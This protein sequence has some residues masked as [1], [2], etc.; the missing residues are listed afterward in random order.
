[1]ALIDLREGGLLYGIH[2]KNTRPAAGRMAAPCP[3]GAQKRRLRAMHP[4]QWQQCHENVHINALR[5]F[6]P[7]AAVP[8]AGQLL[9]LGMRYREGE[10]SQQDCNCD[11]IHCLLPDSGLKL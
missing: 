5:Q 1:M 4:Q 7:Q 9:K 2:H 6:S 3:V 10:R 11:A 8:M